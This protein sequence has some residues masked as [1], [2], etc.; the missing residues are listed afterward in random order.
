[1]GGRDS[2]SSEWSDL[3]IRCSA[4][5]DRGGARDGNDLLATTSIQHDLVASEAPAAR[6]WR[7]CGDTGGNYS[8]YAPA[9]LASCAPTAKAQMTT[10]GMTLV[11]RSIALLW[12]LLIGIAGED[13]FG[14]LSSKEHPM[15]FS[16]R[17]THREN[18]K[19]KSQGDSRPPK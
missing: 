10:T 6:S 1:M 17:T 16:V 2:I 3:A 14:R 11:T 9:A 12:E 5:S 15:A 19:S 4:T 8:D 18:R 7:V 13:W